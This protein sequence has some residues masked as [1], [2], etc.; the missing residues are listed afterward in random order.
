MSS[1]LRFIEPKSSETTVKE[2]REIVGELRVHH[3]IP[4]EYS[5][6][7]VID[8]LDFIKAYGH[9]NSEFAEKIE[10][11]DITEDYL[12]SY[13]IRKENHI[14]IAN[15][16]PFTNDTPYL[17]IIF[18]KDRKVL[19]AEFGETDAFYDVGNYFLRTKM[20]RYTL[21]K[22]E[23]REQEPPLL[24]DS[25]Y[26]NIKKDLTS[27][28]SKEAFY[29]T[30]GI[31]YKRGVLLYGPPG[32][33]KTSLI[34]TFIKEH[35]EIY[36]IIVDCKEDFDSDIGAYLESVTSDIP[37]ILVMEDVDGLSERKRTELL[38]FLDGLK[39]LD[40]TFIIATTNHADK[41]D[42][43]LINRPSRF[44]RVYK[45]DLPNAEVRKAL[46]KRF[47]PGTS[48]TELT[49]HARDTDGFS[50]AYFK[51]L[52][53]YSNLH[54]C[55]LGEA[56]AALVAQ[57]KMYIEAAKFERDMDGDDDRSYMG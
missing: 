33:G 12:V 37:K 14:V 56:I 18:Y 13:I 26:D 10:Q 36:G 54:D 43:A 34:R 40:K 44:D 7:L 22:A 48:D 6:I 2:L 53:I 20:G 25:L 46:L 1:E 3:S 9:D 17:M 8:S 49:K 24:N 27:F 11:R 32:T 41:L 5:G 4:A 57:N 35:P 19:D 23:I 45:I 42:A 15:C 47:F 16:Y 30:A 50:G 51:E 21:T 52:M 28:L 39:S 31:P 38:N 55:S 29:R